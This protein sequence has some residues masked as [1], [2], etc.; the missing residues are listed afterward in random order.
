MNISSVCNMNKVV[1]INFYEPITPDTV[2][3]FVRFVTEVV[4]HHQPDEL[5]FLF[6]SGGGGVEAGFY[7]HNFLKSLQGKVKIT[8][9]NTSSI[10]SISNIVFIAADKRYATPGATFLFHGVTWSFVNSAHTKSQLKEFVSSIANMENSIAEMIAAN[11]KLKKEELTEFFNQGESKHADF[12]LEKGV[13]HAIKV[14]SIPKD[15]IHLAVP[16]V[17]LVQH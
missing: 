13:I 17:P 16:P 12:A 8:M 4:N 14:P 15:A 5:Y 6:A 9:H 2:N 1:Y 10:D 7:L 11:T 3:N